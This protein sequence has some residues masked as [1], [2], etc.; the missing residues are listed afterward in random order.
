M[1][2]YSNKKTSFL[3]L[4]VICLYISTCFSEETYTSPAFAPPP[5]SN[6]PRP[7]AKAAYEHLPPSEPGK[8]YTPSIVPNGSKAKYRVVDGVKVFHLIAEQIVW[9]IAKGLTV[10][11]WGYNGSFPGPLIEVGAGDRVRI[12]VT[13]RLPVPTSV[14]WHGMLLPCGMDGVSGLTQPAINTS[15]K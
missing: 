6:P 8:D 5:E 2:F 14:H 9:E 13:N 10:N 11:T 4:V 3:A 1:I 15:Y 12:Y 7:W